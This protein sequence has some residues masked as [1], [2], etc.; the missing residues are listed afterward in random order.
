MVLSGQ[1]VVYGGSFNPPHMG[2]QMACLYLIE[3]LGADAVWMLPAWVHPFGKA[4]EA[5]EH[6]LQMCRLLAEPFGERVRISEVERE[7]DSGGRTF[8][9]LRHLI[10][11]EPTRRFALAVGT[12]IL[13]ETHA[14]HRW[15]DIQ[16]MVE[17]VVIGR[18]GFETPPGGL[19]LPEVSSS[20]IRALLARGEPIR[21]MVPA[22]VAD[23]VAAHQL[24]RGAPS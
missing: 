10:A 15:D 4:L 23:Y 2:H 8:D 3:A 19:A 11:G 14:W 22:S 24:Y 7:V 18:Q 17:I 13:E 6:R 9:T 12:D 1:T 16:K 20:E 21:G 5:F